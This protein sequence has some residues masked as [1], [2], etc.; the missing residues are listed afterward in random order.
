MDGTLVDTESYWIEAEHHLVSRDGGTWTHQDAMDVVGSDLSR[1]AQLL[2]ER[3]GVR[4]EIDEIVEQ[5]VSHV[6]EIARE[7]GINWRPG[8]LEL[9]EQLRSVGVPCALVTM[10]YWKFASWVVSQL[11]DGSFSALVTGDTVENGKPHPEPYQR[12]ADL[13]GVDISRC[14]AIEDSATGLASAE[15]AGA[16]TIGVKMLVHFDA[17]PARSRFASL[18]Q[19]GMAEI[20]AIQGGAVIDLLDD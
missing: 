13:L 19:V 5:L 6:I 3:G 8:A 20:S 11:P 17:M 10:S 15:A 18:T 16:R 14:I 12:A 9:L 7:R 2:K 4:G 1:T